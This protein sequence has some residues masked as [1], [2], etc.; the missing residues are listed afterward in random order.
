[1]FIQIGSITDATYRKF[2][3]AVNQTI[4]QQKHLIIALEVM[5]LFEH[6]SQQIKGQ[7]N[8]DKPARKEGTFM[9]I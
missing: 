8:I 5:C 3:V 7:S 4:I 1:V 9:G 6:S 2:G